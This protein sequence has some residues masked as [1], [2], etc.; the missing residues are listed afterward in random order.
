M[1]NDES[2]RRI[3]HKQFLLSWC[4]QCCLSVSFHYC[5]VFFVSFLDEYKAVCS[6][7]NKCCIYYKCW[8]Q[9]LAR[10]ITNDVIFWD[11]RK[12]EG[13]FNRTDIKDS[14]LK[15]YV[16]GKNFIADPDMMPSKLQVE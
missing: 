9:F 11:I 15:N 8:G 2:H 13:Y 16:Q 4:V 10:T 7:V 14:S 3:R 5:T 6:P 1:I 12:I